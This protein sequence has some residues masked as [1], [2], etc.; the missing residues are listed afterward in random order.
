MNKK[1][2]LWRST[3]LLLSTVLLLIFASRTSPFYS[4]LL[5]NYEKNQAADAML[6]GKYWLQGTIPYKDLFAVGGPVYF[7]IQAAGWL[8]YG[9][10]G[11]LILE[12]ISCAVTLIY[13]QKAAGLFTSERTSYVISLFSALLYAALCSG[14]NS[15][16]EWCLSLSA[17]AFYLVFKG[18]K[19]ELF[20]V[21]KLICLGI[22]S[23]LT[24]MIRFTAGGAI[25]GLILFT[26][27]F[28]WKKNGFSH[29][30]RGCAVLLAGAAVPVLPLFL[31]FGAA[32]SLS[33]MLQAAF[34]YP[35]QIWTSGFD[36]MIVMIH[37]GIK[38]LLVSP[39][40]TSGMY[41]AVKGNKT[42]GL[43]AVFTA[44]CN[45]LFLI[46]GDNRWYYYL[47]A[48]PCISISIALF[49]SEARKRIAISGTAASVLLII[50]IC[51]IPF[52][53]YAVFLLNGTPEVVDE[54]F[55]DITSFQAEQENCRILAIDTDSSYFLMLNEK[56]ICRYFTSQTE[57]SQYSPAVKKELQSYLDGAVDAD[58][59]L[60]TERGW[61]GQ[62]F[63][64][65]S[66]VQVYCKTGGN[67]CVYLL[68]D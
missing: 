19:D 22:L 16:A 28:I 37:K 32:G 42:I 9:R 21:R 50:A 27:A 56:P 26:L 30:I 47:M 68:N 41:Y 61:T 44:L 24:T 29:F 53:N 6:I 58:V 14:G 63:E 59:V 67:I 25:Y 36:S 54:F 34:L 1:K 18:I 45:C 20:S 23:G 5:G 13:L 40:V 62:D 7:L 8:I 38:C 3:C 48:I 51:L 46:F 11:I 4:L 43:C 35:F 31:Y 39:L 2:W 52:K 12:I 10:T 33:S 64:H 49:L 55:S 65:Y 66:L 17:I 57:L 60:T 15:D